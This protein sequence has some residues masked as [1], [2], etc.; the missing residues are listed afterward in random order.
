MVKNLKA[1]VKNNPKVL[2]ALQT[3]SGFSK[4]QIF[5]HL[6]FGQ[7]P[8]IK[9]EEMT[10]RFGFYN[11]NSGNKTLHIRA[12]Y[13]RGLEQSYLQSTKEAAAFLLAVT[14][15]HEYIHLGTA[16]NN[17]SEGVYDFGLGFERDA[18]NVIVDDD[19]AG[20]VVI[21]FSKYF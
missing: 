4:Q 14:I 18:F 19:N 17:I 12:S 7:G 1:F 11:K 2:N 3:Y 6:T 15:L 9:V 5:N 20:T 10:G 8:T 21:K 16:Q 13:V